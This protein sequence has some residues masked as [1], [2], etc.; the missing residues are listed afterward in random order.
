MEGQ[1]NNWY[2][3]GAQ[4]TAKNTNERVRLAFF[5]D[6]SQVKGMD[7]CALSIAWRARGL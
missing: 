4:T 2:N 7:F 1:L 6:V 3:Q 5:S